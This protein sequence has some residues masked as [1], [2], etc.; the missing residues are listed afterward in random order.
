MRI[1]TQTDPLGLPLQ[2]NLEVAHQASCKGAEATMHKGAVSQTWRPSW[3][4]CCSSC[5]R[6]ATSPPQPQALRC[7]PKASPPPAPP[8]HRCARSA[9][10]CHPKAGRLVSVRVGREHGGWSLRPG[11]AEADVVRWSPRLDGLS[12]PSMG[13]NVLLDWMTDRRTGRLISLAGKPVRPG[14]SPAGGV[15]TVPHYEYLSRI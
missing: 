11:Q 15:P 3:T 14:T 9:P 10:R 4:S 6:R 7:H 1:C 13:G 5:R 2:T 8:T 12:D